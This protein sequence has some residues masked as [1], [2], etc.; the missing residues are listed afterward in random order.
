[1]VS[2]TVGI[3]KLF[4]LVLGSTDMYYEYLHQEGMFTEWITCQVL[5][6]LSDKTKI[7]IRYKLGHG[8]YET[9]VPGNRIRLVINS[10]ETSQ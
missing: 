6:N 4:N 7:Y 2:V 3:G 9:W 5:D 1:M 10:M 8:E